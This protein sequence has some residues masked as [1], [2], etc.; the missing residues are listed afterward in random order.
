M[1]VDIFSDIK[2]RKL[3]K[4]QGGKAVVVY[5]R[6][7]CSIY[8][9]GYY[10]RWD[11]ELPFI[12]SEDTGFEEAYIQEVIKCCLAIDLLSKD[13][14]DSDKVITSKGVQE[15]Y[16]YLVKLKRWKIG[17][18]EYSLLNVQKQGL[19]VQQ[20][21]INVQ[22]T[23]INVQEMGVNAALM[24]ERESESEKESESETF[25]HK[26]FD[27]AF[28]QGLIPEIKLPEDQVNL[29]TETY[30][31]SKG[32]L[33]SRQQVLGHFELFKRI[34]FDGTKRY[35]GER[36]LYQHFLYWMRKQEVAPADSMTV[37]AKLL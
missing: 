10:M 3:V 18:Q 7:L 28:H 13:L 22:K 36:D 6:L 30:M 35:S 23:G 1:D 15:R 33:L 25:P 4:F 17:V 34:M 26:F 27:K 8:K 5:A 2:I 14:F 24:Q 20:P 16:D 19:N 21:Y 31:R 37:K 29:V 9:C 32:R 12:I 11:D